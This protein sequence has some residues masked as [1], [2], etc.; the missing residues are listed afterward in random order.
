MG[1]IS[2]VAL[3]RASIVMNTDLS[4][5]NIYHNLFPWLSSYYCRTYFNSPPWSLVTVVKI[6]FHQHH[7]DLTIL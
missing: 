1:W 2:N 7:E 6:H 5:V 4:L 3:L